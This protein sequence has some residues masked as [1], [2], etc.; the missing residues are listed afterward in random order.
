MS[1]PYKNPITASQLSGSESVSRTSTFGTNFSVLQ[2]GGYMEVYTL[3]D[4]NWSTYGVTSGV[5]QNSGNTIPIQFTKG[6]GS[7]FSRDILTLNSDN[8]SSGRR[9]LGMQVFVQETETV[10]QYTIPN[11]ET[12]WNNLSGLT[13]NSATTITEYTT[14]VNDRSQAGRDF[15]NAWTG[16]TIEGVSGTTREDAR[17]R[18]FYG[19]D[20]Q[21]TG[22]TYFSGTSDLEL[23]NNTGG[24]VTITGLTAPI[25]GGTYNSGTQTLTLTNSLGEDIQV[26]GFTSGGGGSPLTVYDATSGVTAT[27]VTGITFSDAVVTDNG[28]GN[29]SVSFTG[30]T[31]GSSGSSGTSGTSGVSGIDGSSGTSGTSGTSGVSGIDGSS[32]SSGSSGT[33]GTDGSSGTSGTDGS[34]GT[35]GTD[36][37]SGTSGTDGSSGTS[38]TDGSSGTSG[39]DGSSGTSGTSG[40]DGSSG[41]SGSDGSSGTR[42]AQEHQVQMVHQELAEAQEL[43]V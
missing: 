24:T 19:T 40:S 7:A 39:T 3:A 35:S 16:S 22:G 2:I 36:G 26:T 31:S 34:S 13:G 4:L 30:G 43:Q 18:V 15:I 37:S 27:N 28:D 17:W 11:Y 23:Y 38:G 5:I 6:T 9:R 32:G 8:I 21:I 29:I 25:T 1:F 41:T 12:L 10:Y 42:E 20:V 33:S 14:T